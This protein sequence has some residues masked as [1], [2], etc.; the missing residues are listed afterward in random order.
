MAHGVAL[1]A[2]VVVDRKRAPLHVVNISSP[3]QQLQQDMQK[4]S[5]SFQ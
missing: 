3:M 1:A 4:L 2:L 5:I